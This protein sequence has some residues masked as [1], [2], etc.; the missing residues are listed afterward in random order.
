MNISLRDGTQ[1]ELVLR[2]ILTE[3]QYGLPDAFAADDVILDIGAHIGV[4]ALACLARGAGKVICY[5]PDPANFA[6]LEK[7]LAAHFE[8]DR[9]EL[10][11]VAV[12]SPGHERSR[13]LSTR[14]LGT[15]TACSRISHAGDIDVDV[16]DLPSIFKAHPRV[17]LLKMDAEGAEWLTLPYLA[18]GDLDGVEEII[19]ESHT[20]GDHF[21][22]EDI[23]A[24]LLPAGFDTTSFPLEQSRLKNSK[25]YLNHVFHAARVPART[26]KVNVLVMR[27]PYGG[28]ERAEVCD[29]L[30][31]SVFWAAREDRIKDFKIGKLN[32]TP[33][34][35]TRNKAAEI[36]RELGYDLLIMVDSDMVP[37]CEPGAPAFLPA[38]FDFWYK[39]AGPCVIGAPYGG[40]PPEETPYVFRWRNSQ[41]DTP[42]PEARITMYT[43]DEAADLTGIRRCAALPTGLILIDAKA[44][45]AVEPPYFYYEFTDERCL[46]KAST[47]DVTFSRDLDLAGV[48]QYCAWDSWAGHVKTKVVR[49]PQPIRLAA[50]PGKFVAAA[51]R[52]HAQGHER[53]SGFFPASCG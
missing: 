2:E 30:A 37:D 40:P 21:A 22:H 26:E 16:T 12:G 17:R 7:N 20:H 18:P 39:H 4:F 31:A 6:L 38:A 35:M 45:D 9:Y 27:F 52:Q 42:E 51:R 41:N 50:L 33:I 32:D 13:W 46:A 3:N 1:D 11:Q 49:K 43:R 5:E 25:G 23:R 19:G 36:V 10:H 28:S 44:L 15:D 8:A 48:P 29:W 53:V 34:T 47:E 24:W 14:A